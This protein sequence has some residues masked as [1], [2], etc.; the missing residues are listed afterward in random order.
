M[1]K[2]GFNRF[3]RKVKVASNIGIQFLY[4]FYANEILHIQWISRIF[5]PFEKPTILLVSYPR[6]GSTWISTILGFSP[7][8]AYLFE[9]VST[10]FL[11]KTKKHHYLPTIQDSDFDLF[12]EISDQAF[13]GIPPKT[14]NGIPPNPVH[15]PIVRSIKDFWFPNRKNL[16]LLIKEINPQATD[17]FINRYAPDA[18]VLL[19]HPAAVAE[20]H[21]RL[22][23]LKN[24][25]DFE[26]FGYHYGTVLSGA[27][28]ASSRS[29]AIIIYYEDFALNPEVEFRKLFSQ[30]NIRV[31]ANFD[32]ILDKFCNTQSKITG[33]HQ[34]KRV[35]VIHA[36]KWRSQLD[37]EKVEAVMKGY[38]RSPLKYYRD[39]TW[40]T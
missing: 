21:E 15:L 27:I 31:P 20:S 40:S 8:I 36:D 23:F 19:R 17:F 25:L 26:S 38:F 5:A 37:T 29:N 39:E 16:R 13:N 12:V 30:L 2:R 18:I 3:S 14:N 22:G 32:L 6:S 4:R 11:E 34:I 33:S 24:I 7:D 10:P 9:P 1:L 28:E 35:S